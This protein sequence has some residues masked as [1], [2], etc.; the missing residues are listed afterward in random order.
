LSGGKTSWSNR[1]RS[2]P[3]PGGLG[4]LGGLARTRIAHPCRKL[5]NLTPL[6][7]RQ[8]FRVEKT[9]RLLAEN[10]LT[11]TGIAMECGLA[12]S[13]DFGSVLRGQTQ[14]FPRDYRD[15]GRPA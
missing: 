6:D 12:A 9:K 13:T 1:G 3:W 5:T 15:S 2:N 4:G 11:I 8:Q 10:R 7:D 14:C